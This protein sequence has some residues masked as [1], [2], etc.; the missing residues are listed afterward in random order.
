MTQAIQIIRRLARRY[1]IC[2]RHRRIWRWAC[3]RC[4][5]VRYQ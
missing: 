2:W 5:Q 1:G 3:R 4:Q